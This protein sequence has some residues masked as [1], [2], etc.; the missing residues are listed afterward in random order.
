MRTLGNKVA[1]RLA[2]VAAGMPVMPATA[3]L[4]LDVD[5]CVAAAKGIGFPAML[6]ARWAGGG[7]CYFIEVNP[8]IKVKHTVTEMITGVDDL[9]AQIRITEGGHMGVLESPAGDVPRPHPT[10]VPAQERIPFSS[11]ALQ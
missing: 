11:H 5:A 2:A 10:G 1:W 8:R 6:K 7:R 9:K 4:P 3:P